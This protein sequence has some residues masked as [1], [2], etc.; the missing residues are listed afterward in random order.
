MFNVHPAAT[1]VKEFL[2]WFRGCASVKGRVG[3]DTFAASLP[4]IEK[5]FKDNSALWENNHNAP[6]WDKWFK[7]LESFCDYDGEWDYE[8]F[9]PPDMECI[10]MAGEYILFIWS[11][12]LVPPRILLTGTGG[13]LLLWL[14]GDNQDFVVFEPS[15][16]VFR[17]VHSKHSEDII[18]KLR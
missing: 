13:I 15:G 3:S 16:E 14:G 8:G 18:L 7:D 6:E 1:V 12:Q 2:G 9:I 5:W 10:R 4:D 11:S 17:G